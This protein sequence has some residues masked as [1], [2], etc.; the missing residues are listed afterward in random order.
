[1]KFDTHRTLPIEEMP[2][3]TRQEFCD[4]MDSILDDVSRNDTAYIITHEARDLVLCPA[5]W[6]ENRLDHDFDTIIICAVRYA[7]GRNTYMPSLVE[8][9][10]RRWMDCLEEQTLSI[11]ARDIENDLR[12]YEDM[13]DHAMWTKLCDDIKERLKDG[14]GV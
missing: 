6:F 3:V 9:F 8:G 4:R 11:I 2:R 14:R 13:P 7:M 1:M 12:L 10:V 5:S